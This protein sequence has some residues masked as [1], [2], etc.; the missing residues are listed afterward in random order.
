[1]RINNRNHDDYNDDDDNRH[2][3]ATGCHDCGS[4]G[5]TPNH[6]CAHR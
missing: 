3:T 6:R 4:S 5:I 1:V 2:G